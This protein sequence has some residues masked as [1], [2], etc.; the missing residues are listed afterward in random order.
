MVGL[1]GYASSDE[2]EDAKWP[3]EVFVRQTLPSE[4][5]LSLR[6]SSE[7]LTV[8]K[9][10][11]ESKARTAPREPLAATGESA[12]LVRHWEQANHG[13]SDGGG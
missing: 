3:E 2:E 9:D 1:V 10:R 7:S 11:V 4:P 8:V 12:Q 5:P 6:R 13:Q